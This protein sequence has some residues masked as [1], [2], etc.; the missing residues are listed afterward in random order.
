METEITKI[1]SKGQVVIPLKIRND[2][3]INKGSVL[4]VEKMNDLV[5]L[6]K[7]D[8]DLIRQFK[9]SL[10]DVKKGKIKRVA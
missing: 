3:G 7:I 5:I 9:N 6:K 2:L 8:V 1:S 4:A 10:E